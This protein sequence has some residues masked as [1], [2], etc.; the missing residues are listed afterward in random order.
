VA[1]LLTDSD[2][3]N[4]VD[5]SNSTASSVAATIVSP[6]RCYF[7]ASRGRRTLFNDFVYGS[8]L[9]NLSSHAH[10]VVSPVDLEVLEE[11]PMMSPPTA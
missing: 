2:S 4:I 10:V 1:H 6:S 8:E 5:R 9:D 3:A 7:R 11:C